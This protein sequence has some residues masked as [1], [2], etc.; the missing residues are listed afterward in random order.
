MTPKVP[1]DVHRAV[2]GAV[3][4]ANT[5]SIAAIDPI[6]PGLGTRRFYRLRLSDGTRLIARVERPED[7]HKRPPGAGPEP[8]LEPLRSFLEKH[9]IP[10]P[11]SRGR[12]AAAG[13]DLLEDLGSETLEHVGR[14][15]D[16][17]ERRALYAEACGWVPALQRLEAKPAAI[18]AF[19][20]RL[21]AALFALK[22]ERFLE[23]A[24][25]HSLG[26]PPGPAESEAVRAAFAAIAEE[27]AAAPQRFA[28]R[29]FKA[30]NVHVCRP[31]DA[32][33]GPEPSLDHRRL[34][35]CFQ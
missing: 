4:R 27:S 33:P 2:E 25:P 10:V 34:G 14:G 17:V 21:D 8:P 15:D 20:R 3:Q 6:E 26:R 24:L 29:D 5:A 18:P 11:A 28:H 32:G 23:W 22:G 9:G 13:I 16:P 1:D 35:H 30:A 7:P 12:D 31:P 19:G